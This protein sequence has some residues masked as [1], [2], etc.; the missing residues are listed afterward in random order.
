MTCTCLS[1]HR[2]RLDTTTGGADLCAVVIHRGRDELPPSDGRLAGGAARQPAGPHRRSDEP[3]AQGARAQA[4][5]QL[6]A[7]RQVATAQ[8]LRRQ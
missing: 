3:A 7:S 1:V 5:R 8:R 2:L 6:A 4:R